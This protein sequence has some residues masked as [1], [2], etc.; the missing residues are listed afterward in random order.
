MVCSGAKKNPG[1]SCN[2]RDIKYNDMEKLLAQRRSSC[3]FSS[4]RAK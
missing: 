4:L 1:N 3:A 2:Y